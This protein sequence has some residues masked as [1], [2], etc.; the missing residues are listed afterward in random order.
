MK[1]KIKLTLWS[2]PPIIL[3]IFFSSL[4]FGNFN[5]GQ[6]LPQTQP[7]EII[8]AVETPPV[9]T[10]KYDFINFVFAGDI[11]LDRG[12]R[13]SVVKNLN[14][15]YA[16]LFEDSTLSSIFQNADVIFANLEGTASDQGKD[17]HNLYSFR[18]DP[19]VLPT[20]KNAG[21][22][23]LAV[24]NNHIGDWGISAF[25]DTLARL[26]ENGLLYTGG[27]FDKTEA[28]TPTI[29]EKNGMK[30]GFL[31]FSDVGPADTKAGKDTPGILLASDPDFDTIV[32]NA[33][34]QVDF[35]IVS[36]HFGVEYQTKHDARQE[37]L[38]HEAVDDGAKIIIGGHPH[39][40]EDTEVYKN[41]FI[42]YSLGNFIFDQSWSAPTMQGLLLEL[43]LN[44]GGSMIVKKDTTQLNKFFQLENI[45][46]GVAE[47]VVP[48]S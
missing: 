9:V 42:A 27:G 2:L 41:S 29:L 6:I 7:A 30:I 44:K 13:R 21:F 45:N 14:G 47:P 39:V 24:A 36:F 40:P 35:L 10:K 37:F 20:L 22:N 33:T 11:M 23:V 19:A 46:E 25:I 38:A 17:K 8:T 48:K 15:A 3:G 26:K 16:K 12:V 28:E 32:K 5:Y 18:M 34:K 31:A 43:R 4:F 1:S